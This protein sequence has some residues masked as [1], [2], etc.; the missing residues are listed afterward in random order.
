MAVS[1]ACYCCHGEWAVTLYDFYHMEWH[2]VLY[3]FH[4]YENSYICCS[5]NDFHLKP[6]QKVRLAIYN[7]R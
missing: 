1:M 3:V 6:T 2:M 7:R 4:L 5:P